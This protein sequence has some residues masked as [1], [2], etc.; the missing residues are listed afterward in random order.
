MVFGP[1]PAT[2]VAHLPLTAVA[3][4]PLPR[5]CANSYLLT[6]VVRDYWARPDAIHTSDCGAV[7]NMAHA[8]HWTANDTYSAAYA[9]NAGMDLNSNT[10]LPTQLATAIAIGL[11][12]TSVLD[13][14][15][16]RTLTWRFR[17]GQMDPLETQPWM[18]YTADHLGT[19]DNLAAAMEGAAQ[20][21]VLIKNSD[22]VL[23][24]ARGKSITVLGPLADAQEALMGDYYAD[25]V[26]QGSNGYS[27]SG[28]RVAA[29]AQR[30]LRIQL[31]SK[32]HPLPPS[33]PP[34]P[35]HSPVGYGCVPSLAAAINATNEGGKTVTFSGV[36]MK[37]ND[38]S[39]GPALASIASSDVVVLALGSD[40][41]VAGEGV[42]LTDI[43][44][45]GLQTPFG[46]AVLAAA[47]QAGKPV[48]FVL[49]AVFP[50][51]F[52]ELAGAASVVV[53]YAPS[54]GA[55][56]LASALFGAN[57]WG[58]AVITHYPHA[59]QETVA[60]R[61]FSMVPTAANPGRSYRYYNGSS[62]EPLVR[63]G[64]G[65][66]FST[67]ALACRAAYGDPAH[68]ALVVACNVTSTGGPD[69]DQ[70]LQIFHRA[71]PDVI[72]RVAGAHPIPLSTLR[73][74]TRIAVPAGATVPI[75]FS[76][77]TS[78]ALSLVDLTGARVL[79]PGA[80][81]L[82]VWDGSANNV[83]LV[84]QAPV[85]AAIVVARPPRG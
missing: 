59:Y 83:T 71:S 3:H 51:A 49:L 38:S 22:N 44:L 34:P 78:D 30:I 27:N 76:L 43:G 52:D 14:S 40:R 26:C 72:A 85:A 64:Q 6:T 81:L 74:F 42:D 18:D 61:D 82:D 45:P 55:P 58:R 19:P 68:E 77:V 73:D 7:A 79:Y 32:L 36:T 24:L 10:I 80:H 47:A 56:A 67:L 35:F 33:P 54:F 23:P 20:G 2:A 5:S 4:L 46:V 9:L 39:W 28:A 29:G 66:S 50:F 13:A 15:I 41:S 1:P 62:G 17:V 53:G 70:V 12:N 8:T 48:V 16:S 84:V 21:L 37:G 57:R 65:L 60:L 63:F 25:S 31:A 75:T 69:G 11:T